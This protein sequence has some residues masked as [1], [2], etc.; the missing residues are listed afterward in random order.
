M[1]NLNTFIDN[2]TVDE[3]DETTTFDVCPHCG[4]PITIADIKAGLCPSCYGELKKE[5]NEQI[6]NINKTDLKD[7]F[8]DY[9]N[10]NEESFN[11]VYK[12][13]SKVVKKC[14]YSRRSDLSTMIDDITNEVAIILYEKKTE[15]TPSKI[16]GYVSSC[17]DHKAIDHIRSPRFRSSAQNRVNTF[18]DATYGNEG[19]MKI[20]IADTSEETRGDLY[21]RNKENRE[22]FDAKM[23]L[24]KR[25]IN[26]L[27]EDQRTVIILKAKGKKLK[28]IAEVLGI[29][30]ST[31]QGRYQM[32]KKN[33]EKYKNEI[34]KNF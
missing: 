20:E 31:V 13:V 14:I 28:E 23:D 8:L 21:V 25:L 27:P 15:I 2:C 26:K 16:Y 18:L 33:L 34:N 29:N 24:Y 5:N 1:K 12:E 7:L 6:E 30:M 4:E 17:A 3:I 19:E 9:Q 10:G 32:A 11:Y 22:Q